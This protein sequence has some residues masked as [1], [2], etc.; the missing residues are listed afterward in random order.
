MFAGYQD[1]SLC[2]CVCGKFVTVTPLH[3]MISSSCHDIFCLKTDQQ[4]NSLL[5]P[6]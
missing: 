3:V 1:F 2:L 5:L 6:A 4:F